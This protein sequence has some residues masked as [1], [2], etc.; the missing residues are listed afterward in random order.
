M[1]LD[2]FTTPDFTST[3]LHQ[4]DMKL[5]RVNGSVSDVDASK[6]GEAATKGKEHVQ[7]KKQW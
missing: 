1:Q 6:D 2:S 7:K 5:K 3:M 4:S